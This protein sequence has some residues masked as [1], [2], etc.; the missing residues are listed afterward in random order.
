MLLILSVVPQSGH[1]H[2]YQDFVDWQN[3]EYA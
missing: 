1:T 3:F 2:I